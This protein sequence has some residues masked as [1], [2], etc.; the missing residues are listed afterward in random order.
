MFITFVPGIVA[1]KTHGKSTSILAGTCIFVSIYC[2]HI[3]ICISL[4]WA[5]F[6]VGW[7]VNNNNEATIASSP[8]CIA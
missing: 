2:G 8:K 1:Q 4:F 3:C 7:K 5:I 6:V